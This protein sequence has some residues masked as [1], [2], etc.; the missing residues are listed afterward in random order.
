MKKSA[1]IFLICFVPTFLFSQSWQ[2]RAD[3]QISPE[4][5]FSSQDEVADN[6]LAGASL[7]INYIYKLENQFNVYGGLEFQGNSIA[8]HTLIKI[9]SSYHFFKRKNS[10]LSAHAE[11]GN[12]IALFSQRALYSFSSGL[13]FYWNYESKKQNQ[14]SIGPGIQYFTT[15]SYS[16]FSKRYGFFMIPISLKYSF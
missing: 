10:F 15:P 5:L 12:G 11:I 6:S 16:A 7:S 9:G 3:F 1:F 4:G 13:L 2:I 14:W 8:N